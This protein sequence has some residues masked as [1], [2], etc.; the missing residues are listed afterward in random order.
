DSSFFVVAPMSTSTEKG[1]RTDMKQIAKER[2]ADFALQGSA[3]RVGD[4]LLVSAQL[5]DDGHIVWAVK[6]NPSNTDKFDF[7]DKIARQIA[8]EVVIQLHL[9]PGRGTMSESP[10]DLVRHAMAWLY[11]LTPEAFAKVAG[12]A[13][14]AILL[15]PTHARAHMMRAAAFLHR[16][17]F[18]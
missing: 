17:C 10:D 13:E 11:V 7:Q 1:Q 15:E 4:G 9:A 8:S 12:L 6:Y 2:G 18:G 14:Q 16:L 5:I 3:R